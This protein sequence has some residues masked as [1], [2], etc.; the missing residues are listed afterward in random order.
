MMSDRNGLASGKGAAT[1]KLTEAQ[2]RGLERIADSIDG[3]YGTS[4]AVRYNVCKRLVAKGLAEQTNYE[5]KLYGE[6]YAFR[7][8]DLG[9]AALA[10]ARGE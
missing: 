1:A 3:E 2:V 8:T 4:R 6:R 9:R 7:L 5:V 10:R